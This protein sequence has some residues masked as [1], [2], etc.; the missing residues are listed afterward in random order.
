MNAP[1]STPTTL[2]APAPI[3]RLLMGFCIVLATFC[4]SVAFIASSWYGALV[5]LGIGLLWLSVLRHGNNR[6]ADLGLFA[7]VLAAV[8]GGMQELAW[9]WL[10]TAAV[11]GL[12]GWDLAHYLTHLRTTPERQGESDL[13]RGHLS[14]LAVVMASGWLLGGLALAATIRLNLIGALILAGLA[15]ILLTRTVQALRRRTLT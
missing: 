9:G 13:V 15:V 7:F 3:V 2:L 12:A 5:V 6:V 11:A 8:W 10:L 14:R 4:L 1:E